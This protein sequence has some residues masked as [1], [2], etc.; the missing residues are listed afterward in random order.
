MRRT[1]TT[2]L[3][4]AVMAA[5]AAAQCPNGTAPNGYCIE[6]EP[7]QGEK[8]MHRHSYKASHNSY[9][10]E[11][12]MDGQID[13]HNVFMVELDLRYKDG[14]LH[15]EHDCFDQNGGQS[16]NNAIREIARAG[17][18]HQ[19][20]TVIYIEQKRGQET[21]CYDSWPGRNSYFQDVK[22]VLFS[23]FHPDDFY[24]HESFRDIDN[25]TWPSMQELMR[26]GHCLIVAFQERTGENVP[27]PASEN[28]FFG[29]SQATNGTDS[30]NLAFTNTNGG[31]DGGGSPPDANRDARWLKRVYPGGSCSGLCSEQNGGYWDD[32]VRKNY[33]FIA[34]NCIDDGHTFDYDE[35]HSPLPTFVRQSANSDREHGTR[36]RSYVRSSGARTALRDATAGTTI[37][38]GDGTYNLGD[39]EGNHLINK[40][41]LLKV[42]GSGSVFIRAR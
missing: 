40:A 8:R 22:D 26:R 14:N 19:R 17:T 18:L 15:V 1:S 42:N 6:L 28:F 7:R 11:Q 34:T 25:K 38:F 37:K 3:L 24:T 9:Q 23:H 31:C 29:V 30:G 4:L 21:F 12:D 16:F 10:R 5:T 2:A 13:N 33:N 27:A 41:M 35:V 39:G 20:V 36:G 32:G